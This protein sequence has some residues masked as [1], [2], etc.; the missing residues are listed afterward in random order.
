MKSPVPTADTRA[1]WILRD[2]PLHALSDAEWQA[3]YP[4]MAPWLRH[5]NPEIRASA[6]ERLTMAVLSAEFSGSPA[7]ATRRGDAKDRLA[8]LLAEIEQAHIAQADVIT[9][10]LFGLRYHG[11][12]EPFR[13]PLLAWL[14]SIARGSPTDGPQH[15]DA[16][17]IEG[18]RLMLAGAGADVDVAMNEWLALLDHPSDYVR[19]CAAYQLGNVSDED[20]VPDRQTVFGIVGDKERDRPGIAGPFW[21]PQYHD[22]DDTKW[23]YATQWMLDLL[24]QRRGPAP[25]LGEM[26]FNDIEFYLHELCCFSPDLMWRMLRGGHVALALMTATELNQRVEG[27]Q[28]VLEAL[29]SHAEPSIAAGAQRQLAAYYSNR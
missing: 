6:V 5:D 25:P 24:E 3:Y 10:F 19:G 15:V 26:P 27:V 18:T 7:Q 21:S 12:S 11:Y 16:G 4:A 14:A 2:T 1:F 20:T 29:A 8:W 9:Q 22:M 13:T 28:P 17:L 23:Q